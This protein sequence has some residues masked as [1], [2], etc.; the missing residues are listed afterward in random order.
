MGA[1]VAPPL[2]SPVLL[3]EVQTYYLRRLTGAG[4]PE[5]RADCP[6]HRDQAYYIRDRTRAERLPLVAPDGYFSIL[7]PAAEHLAKRPESEDRDRIVR[8]NAPPL[9]ARLLWRLI[10]DAG[11][12]VV[13]AIG[14]RPAPAIYREFHKLKEAA[15]RIEI[16]PAE[17]S[18][19]CS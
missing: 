15:G 14:D 2:L 13:E 16:A 4:R 6:F 17:G 11:S 10:E 12:N 8:P 19:S 18:T 7:K 3:S 1:D 5:H 9:L